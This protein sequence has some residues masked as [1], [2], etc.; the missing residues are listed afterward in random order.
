MVEVT[1]DAFPGRVWRGTIE[2][3]PTTVVQRGTRMVG[4]ITCVLENP[5]LKLLPNT[6]V[7]VAVITARHEN[8]LTVPREALHQ[9]AT[10]QYVFEVLDGALKRRDV[11]TGVS[12]LTRVEITAGLRDNALLA[13]GAINMQSLRA[14]M[15]VKT[16]N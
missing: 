11:K 8:A 14:G 5:D 4:E 7:D 15:P 1:W 2:S 6:N 12:D 16:V 3:L 10:G 9:D 13:I